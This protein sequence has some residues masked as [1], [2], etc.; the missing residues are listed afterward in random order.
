MSIH[1]AESIGERLVYQVRSENNPKVTY[2]VEL[3]AHDGYSQCACKDWATRRSPAIKSK[4]FPI[5]SKEVTCKHVRGAR[6]H[7][8]NHFL[9][10]LAREEGESTTP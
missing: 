2:R 1:V 10:V 9:P 4:A 7:F 8:L 5:G 6:E 3:T